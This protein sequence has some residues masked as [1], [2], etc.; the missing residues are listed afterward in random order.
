MKTT[1]YFSLAW[2][3][4]FQFTGFRSYSD[5]VTEAIDKAKTAYESKNYPQATQELNNALGGIQKITSRL[6]MQCL[7]GPMEGWERTEPT[8]TLD[9]QSTLGLISANA[10]SIEVSFHKK[11]PQQQ[12]VITI[13]NLPNIVQLAK[14]GLQLLSNPFFAKMQEENNPEEKMEAFKVAE[15]EGARTVNKSQKRINV[16]LFY[17]D[18]LV[19]IAGTGVDDPSVVQKFTDDIKYEELKKFSVNS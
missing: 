15:F 18:L 10:Y 7:P 4:L 3:I 17:G 11:D 6:V 13:S 9:H 8:S 1:F 14:A 19:Q 12:V 5:E 2:F 16:H